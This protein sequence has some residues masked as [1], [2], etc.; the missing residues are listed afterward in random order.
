M[1]RFLFKM[2]NYHEWEFISGGEPGKDRWGGGTEDV[3]WVCL[4]LITFM[5]FFP[6]MK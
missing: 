4:H 6:E 2:L 3:L 5:V 1:I